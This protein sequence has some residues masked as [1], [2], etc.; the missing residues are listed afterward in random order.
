MALNVRR[1]YVDTATG[2][3]HVRSAGSGRPLM[4]LHWSP[5]TGRLY[6]EALPHFAARGFQAFAPDLPGHGQSMANVDGWEVEDFARTIDET[7]AALGLREMALLAGHLASHFAVALALG[8]K[9]RITHLV[10]DGTIILTPPEFAHLLRG[11]AA[12]GDTE[13]P[14]G[15][16]PFALRIRRDGRHDRFP[17]DVA[18]ATL[19]EWNPNFAL[20]DETL[21]AVYAMAADFLQCRMQNNTAYQRYDV[22]EKLA[23]IACPTLALSADQEPLR[24][25]HERVL[26]GLRNGRGHVFPGVHPLLDGR[27]EAYV[28]T[29]AAFLA[30]PPAPRAATG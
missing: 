30:A 6:E 13:P 23:A 4:L 3:V 10:L 2:Q 8:G 14:P 17:F 27:V 12:L 26:A 9:T 21:P 7:A 28:E 22:A 29:I 19:R 25:A 18:L 1:S 20:N 15:I 5:T 16:S 11:F 24:P